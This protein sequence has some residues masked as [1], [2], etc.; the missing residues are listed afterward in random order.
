MNLKS[1]L[2]STQQPKRYLLV[3]REKERFQ[4]ASECVNPWR[5]GLGW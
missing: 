1:A 5:S 4:W 3:S 2:K